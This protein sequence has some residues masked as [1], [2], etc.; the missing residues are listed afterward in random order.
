MDIAIISQMQYACRMAIVI[1]AAL[2]IAGCAEIGGKQ[3]S[4]LTSSEILDPLEV[5][6]GMT[7]LPEAEQFPVPENYDVADIK[8]E[9]IPVTYSRSTSLRDILIKGSLQ[10]TI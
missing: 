10:Q 8:P 9:D 4:L 1:F 6:P 2:V 3:L 5:P 7:P